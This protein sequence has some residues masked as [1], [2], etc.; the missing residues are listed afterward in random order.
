M[1][2][3]ASLVIFAATVLVSVMILEF[4][5]RKVKGAA[6]R[7]SEN[8]DVIISEAKRAVD[9]VAALGDNRSDDRFYAVAL[10][11]LDSEAKDPSIWGRALVDSSGD[12]SKAKAL[13]IKYRVKRM[14]SEMAESKKLDQ[15]RG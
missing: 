2:K 13:Y 7:V 11:E 1:D 3:L 10:A 4:I 9:I 8:H 15:E 12:E 5:V 6:S 14:K